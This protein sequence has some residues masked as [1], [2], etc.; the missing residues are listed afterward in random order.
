MFG[1]LCYERQCPLEVFDRVSPCVV[2][3]QTIQTKS[4]NNYH[5]HAGL[6]IASSKHYCATNTQSYNFASYRLLLY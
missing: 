1:V 2:A 4:P 5:V 6:V 3:P